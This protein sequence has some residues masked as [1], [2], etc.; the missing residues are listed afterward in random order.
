MANFVPE[1]PSIAPVTDRTVACVVICVAC[2]VPARHVSPTAGVET[3]RDRVDVVERLAPDDPPPPPQPTP[4][5]TSTTAV[6]APVRARSTTS[7]CRVGTPTDKP[8]VDC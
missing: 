8:G 6:Q 5:K 1:P 2:H 7:G 4:N 3:L